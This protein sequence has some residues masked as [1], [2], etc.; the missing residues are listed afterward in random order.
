M[1][2]PLKSAAKSGLGL[3]RSR[4]RRLQET[5]ERGLTVFVYHDVTDDPAPFSRECGLA[6]SPAAFE[7]QIRFI[8]G[9]FQVI[10]MDRLLEGPV[11]QRA[12]L[13]TFD[14]GL[15]SVFTGALPILRAL[16]L[17]STVFLNMGPLF[18]EPFWAARVVYLCRHVPGF[19]EFALR[20]QGNLPLELLYGGCSPELVR[21]WEERNGTGY[22]NRLPEYL[23]RFVGP[24]E[25]RRA[26]S[27]SLVSFGNHLYNHYG[28]PPLSESR[29]GEEF[30]AN[31]KAL[32]Q[33]RGSRPVF[34]FPFGRAAERHV[35]ALLG[36]GA[37]RLFTGFSRINGDPAGP[38]LHR[39]SLTGWHDRPSRIWYEISEAAWT[40]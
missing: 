30:Q 12:A 24:E 8:A 28:L 14:D 2:C 31:A 7:R 17:P 27:D 19:R 18:G 38:V 3:L 26:D 13:L 15:E 33:L 22:L 37:R 9:N 20:R 21:E 35:K 5:L 39:L 10:S 4:S 11:P 32:S 1:I 36:W 23:G 25:L 16:G 40:S 34:A 29:M 6:V